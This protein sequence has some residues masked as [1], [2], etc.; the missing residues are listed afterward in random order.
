MA[1]VLVVDDEKFI[2]ITLEQCLSE[3][4]HQVDLA[5]NGEHAL[6]KLEENEFELVLLDIKL[7]DIDGI[8]VLRRLKRRLPEQPVVMITAYGTIA[9]AV[10]AIKLGAVDYLQKPFTPEEMRNI[11]G[12]VLSRDRLTEDEAQQSFGNALEF[13]KGC[14]ARH[15]GKEAIPYLKRAIALDPKRPEPYYYLGLVE[16]VR[17][18]LLEALKMYRAALALDPSYRPAVESLARATDWKYRPPDP[19]ALA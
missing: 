7:P 18:G 12:T 3:A 19:L 16:E 2:R 8:E 17:G 9:T 6:Q 1:R 14:I 5:V 13:A 11:V 10:E 4:G 15:H